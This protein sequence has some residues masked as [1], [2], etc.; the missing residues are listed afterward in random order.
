MKGRFWAAA[1]LAALVAGQAAAAWPFGESEEEKAAAVATRVAEALREPNRLI[2]QAQEATQRGDTEEAIRLFRRAQSLMEETEA[3]EDT[4]GSAW[5]SLRMKKFLCQSALDAL[6]LERAEVLDVRQAVTDTSELERRLAEERA[7]IR[8][9]AE[10]KEAKQKLLEPPKPPTLAEQLPGAKRQLAEAQAIQADAGKRLAAAKQRHEAALQAQA[11][12]QAA[13]S[14]ARQ[15]LRKA[16]EARVANQTAQAE[17]GLLAGSFADDADM[18]VARAAEEARAATQ[19]LRLRQDEADSA[20]AHLRVEEARASAARA[21]AQDAQALLETLEKAIAKERAEAEAKARAAQ[22]AA[23]RER[24]RARAEALARKQAQAAAEAKAREAARQQAL[25]DA[26]AKA[27]A[28]A[29]AR[30]CRDALGA[31]ETLWAAKRVDALE[32][33]LAKHA[34]EWP[35]EPG[36]MVLL[37]RLR[38]LQGRPDDA[39]EIVATVPAGS[40]ADFEAQLVAAGAFLAKNRPEESMQVLERAIQARPKDPRPYFNM[41]VAFL[42]LPTADPDREIAARFYAKSVSLGGKRSYDLERR[43]NME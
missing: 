8:K 31:C 15:A 40:A 6:A 20:A 1:A 29:D 21:K 24:E 30:A 16:E 19:A 5:A 28:E 32:A 7:A 38:L 41:A 2:V 23:E 39:L 37:A 25:A 4:A 36:F 34:A 35:D 14:A 33:A 10:A 11:Q 42:R 13:E 17:G 9:E 12:A 26:K 27:A 3:K 18:A 22:A 43:L